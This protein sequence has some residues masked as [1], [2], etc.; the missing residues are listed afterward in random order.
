[1][2]P[3]RGPAARLLPVGLALLA[4]LAS[5]AAVMSHAEPRLAGTNNAR[6]IAY[7][8]ELAPGDRFCQAGERV[9][10]DARE[11]QL[12]VG[13][14]RRPGP[15]LGVTIGARPVTVPGGYRQGSLLVDIPPGVRGVVELC[16]RNEGSRPVFLGG[17][18]ASLALPAGLGPTLAGE[19]VTAVARVVYWRAG[20]ETGWT[21]AGAALARWGHVTAL[22]ALTPWLALALLLGACAAAVALSLRGRAGPVAVAAV[23][24]AAAAG[25]A[26]TTPAFQVPDEPQHVAYAQYLAETGELPRPEPLGVFS[27]EEGAV[28]ESIA[29]NNVISNPTGRAAWSDADEQQL[30][31]R[32]AEE[33]GR[34]SEGGGSNTTNNPPLYYA[35]QV[36]P[37]ELTSSGDFLDRLLAMR[38]LSALL[39]GL[40]AGFAFLFLRELL[41]GTPWA[42]TAGALALALQPLLGFISGGVN[43]DAGMYAAGAAV[44]WLVARAFRRG[45][46]RGT[47][48]GIGAA[49][50][51]GIVTKVSVLGLVPGLLVVLGV[52]LARADATGRRQVLARAGLATAVA[53]LPVLAYLV[54]NATV[55]DRPLWAA[56][57]TSSAALG[58]RPAHV[59]EFLSY[60]WQF[61]LPRLPFMTDLQSG[62][63]LFNVWFKG[64]IGRYGWLDTTP[65]E[66]A[67]TIAVA[68]YGGVIALAAA[69]LWRGRRALAGRR[70]EVLAYATLVA[71]FLV[72]VG[73]A[74]Y[75]GRLSNGFI[76][77]QTR[78]LLPL[79]ALFAALIALA[80]RGAGARMGPAVGTA[81]V[82]LVCGHALLSA[83]L[84]VGRFYV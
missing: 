6:M 49:M 39:A 1:M 82:V 64:F 46:D 45:L 83:L 21:I 8:I 20:E 10:S 5:L 7:P 54:L 65:P 78:Y 15:A 55:W 4:V 73:W 70:G 36:I 57:A 32:L 61:Y 24:V 79:G 11:L 48:I 69:A 66:W 18:D 63:P 67:Y 76:F 27:P 41:P 77:E 59:T 62:L 56:S 53:A 13:T 47:A 9:P 30:E 28:F 17:Q 50:G 68:I 3:V 34:L 2:R 26:L 60:L 16:V 74:G 81:L 84:V 19:P 38:L 40:T 52:L 80:A 23:A 58:G 75:T 33:P 22:G 44:L 14:E 42:W 72:L 37:L 29:F 43:N 51:L 71:G 25:W 31:Q 35:V 12:E